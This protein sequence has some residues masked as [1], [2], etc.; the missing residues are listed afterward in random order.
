M[1]LKTQQRCYNKSSIHCTWTHSSETNVYRS[2]YCRRT[3]IDAE[4]ITIQ[5]EEMPPRIEGGRDHAL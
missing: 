2:H 1:D 4:H 3:Y 5:H